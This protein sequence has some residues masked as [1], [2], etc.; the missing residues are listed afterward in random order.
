MHP[1]LSCSVRECG[2][3]LE[4][5]ARRWT[6]A[7]GHSFDVARS[8]HINLLQPQDRRSSRAGD[9]RAAIEARSR[10]LAAGIGS[11]LLSHVT[12]IT[13]LIPFGPDPV[14]VE[15]GCGSG[16]ML[17]RLGGK[18]GGRA[19]GIDLA[20]TAVAR[21]VKA[22]P[23]LTWVVANADRRLPLLDGSVNLVVSV[24]ARR[25]PAECARV[26]TSD[27][28]LLVAVPAPDD[29]IELREAIFGHRV[30]RQRAD[31][32]IAEHESLFSLDSRSEH[33]E[34]L[35]LN[36]DQLGDLLTGTYRGER[37]AARGQR[38]ALEP[39]NVT[40]ASE[41]LVFRRG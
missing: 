27:G 1:P 30:E 9:P 21:A 37:H 12:D 41:I 25:N 17:E 3:P 23:M 39:M 33:R 32:V 7:N 2:R 24:H 11:G 19:V 10:L 40:L 8:G 13:T 15:L 35:Q 31:G 26:L 36:V 20:Q 4:P 16:E 29:L 6:C 22:W 5:I 14:I 34:H 38:T 28:R 18:H